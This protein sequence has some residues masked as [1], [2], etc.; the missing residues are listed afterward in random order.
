MASDPTV[1]F[2]P[3]RASGLRRREGIYLSIGRA[4]AES[5]TTLV[6]QA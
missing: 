4:E 3:L 1:A 2:V 6:L 5:V